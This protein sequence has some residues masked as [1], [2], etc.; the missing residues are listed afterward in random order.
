MMKGT[1]VPTG[2][3]STRAKIVPGA[4]HG[5]RQHQRGGLG[6]VVAV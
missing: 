1:S 4:A 3:V 2:D 5:S 6:A